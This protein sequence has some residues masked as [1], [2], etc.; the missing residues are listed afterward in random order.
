[1]ER[2]V[3]VLRLGLLSLVAVALALALGI[4]CATEDAEDAT[5]TE[6][7]LWELHREAYCRGLKRC[8]SSYNCD[9]LDFSPEG[10]EDCEFRPDKAQICVDG[11]YPCDPSNPQ[12][13]LSPETCF[14]VYDCP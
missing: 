7:E 6:D 2:E 8:K 5:I 10:Y 13:V 12:G 1:M 9:D 3:D 14:R 4:G 11:D